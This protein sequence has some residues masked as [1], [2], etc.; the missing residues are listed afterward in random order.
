MNSESRSKINQPL[1]PTHFEHDNLK[2]DLSR[3]FEE[4]NKGVNLG[5]RIQMHDNEIIQS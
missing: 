3:A 4:C 1:L 2:K 5:N